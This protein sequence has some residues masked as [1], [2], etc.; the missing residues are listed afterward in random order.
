MLCERTFDI[1]I[2]IVGSLLVNC[3]WHWA[4]NRHK[5]YTRCVKC[6]KRIRIKKAVKV[7]TAICL[8]RD[9][10]AP[11]GYYCKKCA[12]KVNPDYILSNYIKN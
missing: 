6:N 12:E 9:Y 7:L 3:I 10:V 5:Y 2:I 4:V 8:S 11:T 1:S